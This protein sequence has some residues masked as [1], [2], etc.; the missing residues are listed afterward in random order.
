MVIKPQSLKALIFDMD[1][2]MLDS[3]KHWDVEE[4]ALFQKLVPGWNREKHKGVVGLN[5][6]DTYKVLSKAGLTV[7]EQEFA[8]TID[9]LAKNIYRTKAELMPG[10]LDLKNEIKK[11]KIP[12]GLASSSR[13]TWIDMA[14]KKLELE[15]FFNT[16]TSSQEIKGQGKPAPDLYLLAAK[17]MGFKPEECVAIEDS[18]NGVKSAKSAGLF[19]IGFRYGGNDDQDH[20][21]ADLDIRGFTREN[22]QKIISLIR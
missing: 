10:F 18:G 19:T 13:S 4:F 7:P 3:E 8:K 15:N 6:P 21:M 20:S 14:L 17:K 11:R 22:N 2:V 16:I 5:I 1:G 9:R 12:V